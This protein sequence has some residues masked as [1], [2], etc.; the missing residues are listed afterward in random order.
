[1]LLI[2]TSATFA[3]SGISD[4]SQSLQHRGLD[5]IDGEIRFRWKIECLLRSDS[6]EIFTHCIFTGDSEPRAI[7][8]Y[9]LF[10]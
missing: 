2:E 5:Y 1:L 3:D 10:D 6:I 4:N 8:D 9:I 7:S